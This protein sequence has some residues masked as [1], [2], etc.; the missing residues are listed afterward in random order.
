[1]N[2]FLD[3]IEKHKF[4]IVAAFAT[5]LAIFIYVQLPSV[6]F[7]YQLS[8]YLLAADLEIPPDEIQLLPENIAVDLSVA[9]EIKNAVRD[10][11]DTRKQSTKNW[12]SQKE[13]SKVDQSVEELEKQFYEE[14][15]GKA[16]RDK[17]QADMELRKKEQEKNKTSK[18]EKNDNMNNAGAENAPPPNVLAS[19]NLKNRTNQKL[20]KPGYLCPQGT[21]GKVTV[22]IKVDQNGYVTEAKLDAANS[23]KLAGCMVENAESYALKARFN[24]SASAPGIQEG[25]ITYTYVP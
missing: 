8:P 21:S 17:I 12:S 10:E 6:E 23:T 14:S 3:Q 4:G 1:M 7:E 2:K 5:Y 9:R 24:I 25:T 20:P 11:N 18:S 22:R 15:G 13:M 19:W 16:Q